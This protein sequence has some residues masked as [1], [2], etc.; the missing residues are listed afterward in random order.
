[1]AEHETASPET[2]EAAEPKKKAYAV[3]R[4]MERFKKR[5]LD[6][7]EELAEGLLDDTFD[8]L[9][10]EAAISKTPLDDMA[11]GIVEPYRKVIKEKIDFNK[12]GK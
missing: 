9:K 3:S 10:E 11:I 7:G 12:D 8:W 6:I 4:L 5:G 1:M 2:S